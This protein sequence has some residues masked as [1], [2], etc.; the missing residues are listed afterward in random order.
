MNE[1]IAQLEKEQM[2]LKEKEIED[3]K[4]QRTQLQASQQ[5]EMIAQRKNNT[6]PVNFESTNDGLGGLSLE[7][8]TPR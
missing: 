8:F 1:L 3:R 2:S 4:D 7:S 6:A 5:S